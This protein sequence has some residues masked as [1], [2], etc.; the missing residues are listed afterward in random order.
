MNE[1]KEEKQRL[2]VGIDLPKHAHHQIGR[3]QKAL[4]E[5]RLF[6]GKFTRPD[7]VHITIKFIGEV[8]P[9]D[10]QRI[11][12]VL[13]SIKAKKMEARLDGIDVFSMGNRIKI[14]FLNIICKELPS[15]AAEVEKVLLPWCEKEERDFV[16]H[17][18]VA[19]VK[20]VEDR[21]QLRN[22]VHS[23]SVEPLS[24]VIEQFI[25]KQSVLLPEGP[26]YKDLALYEL[27]D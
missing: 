16:N 1:K 6:K 9:E 5:S 20:G 13:Q 14:I 10:A 18:T 21:E 15:L 22:F 7:Q 11:Q 23:F 24:F 26:E 2:F 25:L 12:T 17:A 3:I 27:L 19:R 8:S 4:Q